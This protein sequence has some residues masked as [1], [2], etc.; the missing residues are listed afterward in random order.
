VIVITLALIGIFTT[1]LLR[2]VETFFARRAGLIS[3]RE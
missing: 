1:A 2:Y 3:E